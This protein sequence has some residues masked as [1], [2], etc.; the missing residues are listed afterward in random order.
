MK[1]NSVDTEASTGLSLLEEPIVVPWSEV[2]EHISHSHAPF[3]KDVFYYVE[4][5]VLYSLHT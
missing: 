5:P 1:V 3:V 4:G 2:F